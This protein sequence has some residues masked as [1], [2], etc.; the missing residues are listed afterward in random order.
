MNPFRYAARSLAR[1]RGF[2]VATMGTIALAVGAGCAV[3]ALVNAVLLRPLPY[4]HS[5]RLVGLWHSMPGINLPIAKVAPGTYVLYRD[6]AKSFEDIGIYIELAATITYPDRDFPAERMRLGWMTAS[7]FSVLQAKPLLG[8]LFTDTD[9]RAGTPAV[10]L[11]SERLWR[12]RFRGE[13]DVIGHTIDID[14]A[15]AQI[16]GVMPRSFAFPEATTPVWAPEYNAVNPAY[17]GGFAWS[18]IARL[19]PGATIESAQRELAQ[20]L[21]RLADRFP[22]LRPGLSTAAA[23]RQTR[24]API[25]HR[26]RDDVVAGSDR[27]LWLGAATVALLCLVAFS[28]V[29]SLLLVRVESRRRE[30][31][32]R[33]ALGASV[34]S[35][36]QQLVAESVIVS[37]LGGAVGFA[38]AAF[39]LTALPLTAPLGLPRLNEVHV[40]SSTILCALALVTSFALLS[41]SIG[42]WRVRGGDAMRILRDGGR[43]GT[44]GR[45]AQRLRAAFVAI[46]VALSLVLLASSAVLGRS[47]LRLR[48]VE[49]GFDP[50]NTFTF[51]TFLPDATYPGAK[52]AA[53][54][55]REAI[56]RFQRIPGVIAVGATAKLPLVIEGFP[57]RILIWADDGSDNKV[58]PPLFQATSTSA[59]YFGAM[60][61]PLI[62]GRTYDDANV[63]RGALEAVASRAFVEHFW[64]DPTGRAGVGKRIRPSAD[65]PWFTIVGVVGDVRDST[66]TQPPTPEVYF[67]EEPTAE[68]ATHGTYT[69]ARD[70]AFVVRTRL[71]T[72]AL[73]SRLRQELHASDPNLPF[74]RPATMEQ[75]LGDARAG[76]TFALTLLA[77]GAAVTLLL[78]VIGLY[79]VIAYVVSLRSREISIRI[80]LGLDPAAA[81]RMILRQGEAIVVSGAAAGLVVFLLFARLL[82]TF[83]FG[84]NV[85]DLTTLVCS[86]VAVLLVATLATWVPARRAARVDP[87]RTLSAE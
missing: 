59:S 46:E 18:G 25:V 34:W 49:P 86:V 62:A 1:S 29:A 16:I 9:A 64:H 30:L 80:A 54:F 65:G 26:M 15:P 82:T 27:V 37:S 47:L 21:P 7:V 2:A 40:D 50:T 61:I 75:I 4:P 81:A 3:F 38:I 41:A 78:G 35:T 33:S 85:L 32:V 70:M 68:T 43:T 6:A 45:A 24:P 53:R 36:W 10:V 63:G 69:T 60:R 79:G 20:L 14:G 66:L 67:P 71:P 74:Y 57:Y 58:L 19:R 51:W 55:Y 5:E 39:A 17:V 23:L 28:N 56:Q 48:D 11:I 22:Q 72:P 12:S 73:L 84:V 44:A 76:M 83:A 42:A 31:A 52:D 8:R 13:T 77:V 87:A